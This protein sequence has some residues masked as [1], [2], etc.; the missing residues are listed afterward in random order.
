VVG[1]RAAPIVPA[2]PRNIN[3]TADYR[4]DS[5][6]F[7]LFIE[8][9]RTVHYTVIGNGAGGLTQLPHT[10]NK[11][12]DVTGTVQQAVFGMNVKM[13]EHFAKTSGVFLVR[14]EELGVRSCFRVESGEWRVGSG[15]L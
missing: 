4:L 11:P 3:L 9:Y 12:A 8:V 6:L 2:L 15:E 7:A 5:L 1:I 10:G 14:S 13:S